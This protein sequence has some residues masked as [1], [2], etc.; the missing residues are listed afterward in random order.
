MSFRLSHHQLSGLVNAV[1]WTIPV[2]NHAIDS[3]TDH[4]GDLS[5]DLFRV[6]RAVA[7]VHVV[8]AAKPQQQMGVYFRGGAGIEQTVSV[9]F[10]HIADASIPVR[11]S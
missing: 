9:D 6:R 4:I 7:D 10:T 3:P 1:V 8:R 11:L 5:M 2:D